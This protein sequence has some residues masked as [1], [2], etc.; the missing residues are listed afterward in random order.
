VKSTERQPSD[1][2][3]RLLMYAVG[4][5]QPAD[6]VVLE[7]RL[8]A[9][10]EL[11]RRL[12]SLRDDLSATE[13]VFDAADEISSGT[14]ERAVMRAFAAMRSRQSATVAA[15]AAKR[16]AAPVAGLWKAPAAAAAAVVV[17]GIG[18]ALFLRSWSGAGSR[19][20]AAERPDRPGLPSIQPDPEE[21]AFHFAALVRLAVGEEG[22]FDEENPADTP[23]S[24]LPAVAAVEEPPENAGVASTA[25]TGEPFFNV[26]LS[27][28]VDTSR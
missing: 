7:Q 24:A 9:D 5:L 15:P 4:E 1:E 17:F 2:D 25:S 13:S 21:R 14:I 11:R 26:P 18:V 22:F 23:P 20:L 19:D 27:P 3:G 12:Q 6:A 8:A 16:R 28:D 10:A